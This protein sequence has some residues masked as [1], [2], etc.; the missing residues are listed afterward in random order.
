MSIAKYVMPLCFGASGSVRVTSIPQSARCASVFHTF[1]PLTIHSSPSRTARDAR[2]A[3]SD[4]A[5]GS[6]NSWHH[7]SSPVNIGR[8]KRSHCS[9]EP[10][11]KMVGPARAMKNDVGSAGSA[12][13]SRMRR[14]T[15]R[16]RSG[17][18]P[19]PPLPSGKCT[20]ARP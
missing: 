16:L 12:P 11:V 9:S 6:E 8:R 13:A 1:W 4:P 20:Q 7:F 10:W 19:S 17:R 3:K 2:P 15:T 18:R 5:P 14:S